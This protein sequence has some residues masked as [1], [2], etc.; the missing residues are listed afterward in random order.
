MRPGVEV[1]GELVGLAAAVERSDLVI[2]GEGQADE[3]TLAGKAAMGVA[4]LARPRRTPVVLLCGGL[5]PGAAALAAAMALAVVQPIID[6]P[7]DLATA[8]A[9]T[10]KLLEAAASRLALRR[11]SIVAPLESTALYK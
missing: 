9:E 8:M 2:T 3:Q 5:G 6:R 1:V 11:K 10:A 7:I 4:S